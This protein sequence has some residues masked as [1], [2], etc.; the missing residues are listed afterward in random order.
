MVFQRKGCT[1][2]FGVCLLQALDT[3]IIREFVD[4]IIVHKAEK[5]D[6]HRQQRIQIV[7]NCIGI[8]D[9]PA[10]HEKTA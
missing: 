2:V 5:I 9:I 7:Y 3:E 10:R 4:R 6:G 8:V 1:I